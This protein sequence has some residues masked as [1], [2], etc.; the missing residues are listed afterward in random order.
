MA[1]VLVAVV[2]V[3]V[4]V[5]AAAVV[6]VAV[7]VVGEGSALLPL[8]LGV[9]AGALVLW[10]TTILDR[11]RPERTGVGS[12]AMDSPSELAEEG[13]VP[14]REGSRAVS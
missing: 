13:M 4:V 2:V 9:G 14:G 5:S 11:S 6:T 12:G 7:V 10:E 8:L 1:D 3:T